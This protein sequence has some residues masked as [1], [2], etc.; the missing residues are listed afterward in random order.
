MAICFEGYRHML[1]LL[2]IVPAPP[3]Y[4]RI[5]LLFSCP[6]FIFSQCKSVIGNYRKLNLV[7][8]VNWVFR[9][10]TKKLKAMA[11]TLHGRERKENIYEGSTMFLLYSLKNQGN[12]IILSLSKGKLGPTWIKFFLGCTNNKAVKFEASS[13]ANPF[14]FHQ[15]SVWKP[16]V[17]TSPEALPT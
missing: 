11:F 7:S 10:N 2:V 6:L 13:M 12:T 16:S 8:T 1:L 14:P 9:I 4:K 5:Y 15:T 3:A 17:Y